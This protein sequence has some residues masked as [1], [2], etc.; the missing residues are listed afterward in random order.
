MIFLPIIPAKNV[1]FILEKSCCMV[2]DLRC[3]N[4]RPI[5]IKLVSLNA[6]VGS[7]TVQESP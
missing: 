6:L 7:E 4:Y 3:L 5:I 1:Q 2:F